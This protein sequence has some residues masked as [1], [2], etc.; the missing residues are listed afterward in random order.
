M[1]FDFHGRIDVAA[2]RGI[3]M[4]KDSYLTVQERATAEKGDRE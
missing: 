1:D 2:S 3:Q 4:L